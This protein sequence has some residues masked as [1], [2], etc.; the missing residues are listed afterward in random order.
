ML[1]SQA[2][3]PGHDECRRLDAHARG[4]RL[5]AAAP[6]TPSKEPAG[7]SSP[8]IDA[9]RATLSALGK[10]MLPE[11]KARL[12]ALQALCRLLRQM[13]PSQRTVWKQ[14]AMASPGRL[15]QMSQLKVVP[16]TAALKSKSIIKAK[17]RCVVLVASS[18]SVFKKYANIYKMKAR[19]YLGPLLIYD[20]CALFISF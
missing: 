1:L 18:Y 7:L 19:Q 20:I 5:R 4:G 15:S 9:L 13:A 12:R 16:K 8:S 11:A 17:L 2:A 3:A 6:P 10:R 14:S